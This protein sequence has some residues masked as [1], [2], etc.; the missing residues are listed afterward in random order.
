MDALTITLVGQ[1]G[2]IK[3]EKC[4]Q[5][6]PEVKTKFLLKIKYNSRAAQNLDLLNKKKIIHILNVAKIITVIN[7]P[8]SVTSQGSFKRRLL[9]H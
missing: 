2:K 3:K 9:S 6:I 8:L 5:P 7:S 4:Q 1:Q